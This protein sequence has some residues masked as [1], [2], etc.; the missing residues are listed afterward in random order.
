MSNHI[1][2]IDFPNLL[3]HRDIYYSIQSLHT[4]VSSVMF[5]GIT[6]FRKTMACVLFFKHQLFS[7]PTNDDVIKYKQQF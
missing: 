6:S 3:H 4:R 5:N 2:R 1:T 7:S